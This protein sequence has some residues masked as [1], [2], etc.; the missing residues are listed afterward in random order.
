[1]P[2][3]IARMLKEVG[4]HEQTR[5]A[6][7]PSKSIAGTSLPFWRAG[8]FVRNRGV[9]EHSGTVAARAAHDSFR[10]STTR[11]HAAQED[12]EFLVAAPSPQLVQIRRDQCSE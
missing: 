7:S 5:R 11:L 6:I 12:A 1:M 8:G 2:R 3:S 9:S 4:Y 10:K